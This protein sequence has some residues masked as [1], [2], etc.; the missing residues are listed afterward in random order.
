M[1]NTQNSLVTHAA[2]FKSATPALFQVTAAV[3]KYGTNYALHDV[4]LTINR[5]EKLAIVG[6]SG[7]GKTTLLRA[8]LGL[9]ALTTGSIEFNGQQFNPKTRKTLTALRQQSAAIFQDPGTSFNPLLPLKKSVFEPALAQHHNRKIT[10]ERVNK[11]LS[12]LA[13]PSDALERYPHEFSGGQRQRLAALRALSTLP[14]ILFADEPVSA[15]DSLAKH[16]F[17][18]TLQESLAAQEATT[19]TPCTLITVTHD[20]TIVPLLATR[21]VVFNA[22]KIVEFGEVARVFADPQNAY[23]KALLRAA[24]I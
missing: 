7:S 17:L 14:Q 12:L 20:L 3:K 9:T 11:L 21:V 16:K 23:T 24:N 13:L 19:H 10:R 15:L 2:N 22:G 6:A 18:F 5:G 4:N 1:S 8:L